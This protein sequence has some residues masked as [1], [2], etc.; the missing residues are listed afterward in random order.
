MEAYNQQEA[1]YEQN[2]LNS[3]KAMND[4]VNQINLRTQQERTAAAEEMQKNI[5]TV[6][7]QKATA[8]ATAGEAGVSGLS[9]DMLLG[10]LDNAASRDRSNIQSN[11][12]MTVAQLDQERRAAETTRDNRINS[13]PRGRK[14][15]GLG[16]AVGIGQAGLGA[17]NTAYS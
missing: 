3:I 12:D 4:E 15:S 2:R 5:R 1:M 11:L 17:Y 16:L 7:A 9:V 10:E 8:E 13:V 6:T 14:P